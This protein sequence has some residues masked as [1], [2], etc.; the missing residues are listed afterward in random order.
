MTVKELIEELQKYDGEL[1]VHI[2]KQPVRKVKRIS[3]FKIK[4]V[5]VCR[6]RETKE[7]MAVN[8]SF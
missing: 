6:M 8:I 5:S 7:I 1:E 4:N 2:F 3:T